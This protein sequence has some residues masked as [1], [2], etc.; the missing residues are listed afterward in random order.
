VIAHLCRD[1]AAEIAGQQ[2]RPDNP[3]ARNH[4]HQRAGQQHDA[5]ED[6]AALRKP[7][8]GSGFEEVFWYP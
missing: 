1:G 6:N 7:K 8:L 5:D 4:V 3:G 2:H